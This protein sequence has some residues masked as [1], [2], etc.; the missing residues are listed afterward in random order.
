VAVSEEAPAGE[1]T[2][3]ATPRRLEQARRRGQVASSRDLTS[4][5]GYTAAFAVLAI[6]APSAMARL[7]AYFAHAL[8][9]AGRGGGAV[10]ALGLALG[11][12]EAVLAWPLAATTGA[13]VL[14][15][16][17]QAGGVLTL[18]PVRFDPQRILPS[19]RRVLNPSALVEVSKGLAK[20]L[21]VGALVWLT[22][23]QFLRPLAALPGARAAEHGEP[24]KEH[25]DDKAAREKAGG[26]QRINACFAVVRAEY[27]VAAG[28][29]SLAYT[30]ANGRWR[31]RSRRSNPVPVPSANSSLVSAGII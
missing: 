1:R 6:E 27:A 10:P 18:E 5:M 30:R 16:A 7:Y 9:S 28:E 25:S 14:A 8:A 4:A 2:E 24:G 26:R 12:V 21:V 29:I 23:R 13:A 31:S 20:V 22:V 3:E 11:Q 17:L 19:W 15:G